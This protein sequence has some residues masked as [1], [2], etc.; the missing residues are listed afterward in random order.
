[1]GEKFQIVVDP[2]LAP[3]IPRYFEIRRRELREL[4]DALAKGDAETARMLGHRLRGTGASYG[5]AEL[6]RMGAQLE[7]AGKA[8]DLAAA[9]RLADEIERYLAD[10]EV[11]YGQGR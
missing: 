5:F 3:L 9:G 2:D 8:R 1:M 7:E 10:V 4:K 11:V 6:T